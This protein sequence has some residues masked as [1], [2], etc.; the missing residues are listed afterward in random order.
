M[1]LESVWL[2]KVVVKYLMLVA[3][4]DVR[5]YL[6][7]YL[8]RDIIVNSSFPADLRIKKKREFAAVRAEGK[9]VY[10]FS[11]IIYVLKNQLEHPRL[12]LIVSKKVS[13]KAVV[14]NKIKR[15]L[16]EIFRLNQN[17]LDSFD[18]VIIAKQNAAECEYADLEKNF[19]KALKNA[20][21]YQ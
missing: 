5:A 20:E 9:K 12:G 14:R 11:L 17:S 8:E 1:V 3:E 6:W 15:R 10:T 13:K 16:R 4:R 19:I 2:L 18:M 21:V 7:Q